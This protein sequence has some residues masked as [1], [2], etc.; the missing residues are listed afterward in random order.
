MDSVSVEAQSQN[1]IGTQLSLVAQEWPESVAVAAPI[2]RNPDRSRRY[3]QVTF[4]EL[5]DDSNRVAAALLEWGVKP[6]CRL[7]L[8]VRPGIDFISLTFALFKAGVVVVLID[9]G[10]GKANLLRCLEETNPD[11]FVAIPLVHAI[12]VVQRRR[13]PQARFNVTVGTPVVLARPY[14]RRNKT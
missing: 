14:A 11:G 9:P 12:R 3:A 5:D 2:G 13:F 7:V 4:R 6:G 8:M 1:N 10:M